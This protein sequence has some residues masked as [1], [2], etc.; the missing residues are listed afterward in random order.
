MAVYATGLIAA[1]VY[2]I[3]KVS[4]YDMKLPQMAL[5]SVADLSIQLV[6]IYTAKNAN[7]TN[8]YQ[9]NQRSLTLFSAVSIALLA[10]TMI[11]SLL[12]LLNFGRGLKEASQ[13]Q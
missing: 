3:W 4:K 11:S 2:F 10:A 12:V 9:S 7:G 5:R 13:S 6:R 8:P 1:M